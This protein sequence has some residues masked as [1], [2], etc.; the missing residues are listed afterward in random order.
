M[1]RA[2]RDDDVVANNADDD[3]GRRG[4]VVVDDNDVGMMTTTEEACDQAR[5]RRT[6][7]HAMISV[8]TILG[9]PPRIGSGGWKRRHYQFR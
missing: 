5:E 2:V 4:D 8:S 7:G 3:A 9:I 1:T 6:E